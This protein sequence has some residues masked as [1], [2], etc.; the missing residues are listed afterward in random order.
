MSSIW[1]VDLGDLITRLGSVVGGKLNHVNIT[2][3]EHA[4][5]FINKIIPYSYEQNNFIH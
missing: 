3:N 4:A 1:R 2:N 5:I